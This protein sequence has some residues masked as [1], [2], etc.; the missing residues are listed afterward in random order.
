MPKIDF[1]SPDFSLG[2]WKSTLA[3][4]PTRPAR[5]VDGIAVADLRNLPGPATYGLLS[6][7]QRL[8]GSTC[9]WPK[10]L[11][12]GVAISRSKRDAAHLPSHFRP[13]V[14][15]N[16]IYRAWARLCAQPILQR[17]SQVVSANA[18]GFL[19]GRE[20][21]QIWMLLQSYIELWDIN[22]TSGSPASVLTL[23]SVS[24]WLDEIS[25]ISWPNMLVF[26]NLFLALGLDFSPH[27]GA[28]F[29]WAPL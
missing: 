10:Q 1:P 9:P 7:L 16:C 8:D 19:P 5:G 22:R 29:N 3:R 4:F 12:Q 18:F 26:Q 14:I 6:L 17:L 24:I 20:C 2:T 21:T 11:L 23:R 28:L 13:V 27:V 15:F 25:C